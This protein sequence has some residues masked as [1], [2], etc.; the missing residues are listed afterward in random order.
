M[1]KP[2]DLGVMGTVRIRVSD[3]L[4]MAAVLAAAQEVLDAKEWDAVTDCWRVPY[5][6]VVRLEGM[7]QALVAQLSPN[8]QPPKE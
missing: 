7:V 1:G 2:T 5:E 6:P 8:E 3:D 4:E